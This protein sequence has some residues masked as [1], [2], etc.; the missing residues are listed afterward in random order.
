MIARISIR[1]RLLLLLA[2]P[3]A[4]LVLISSLASN[5]MAKIDE[6]VGRIYD[7]RVVPLRQL[8]A[9]A[10]DYAVSIIDAVNKAN[11]GINPAEETLQAVRKARGDIKAN[12]D[13][14]LKTKLTADEQRLISQADKL[15]RLAEGEI[16]RLVNYL[17]GLHGI[18]GGKMD[19]FDGPLYNFIDPI[20]QKISELV[21]LQLDVAMEERNA[22]NDLYQR[23]SFWFAVGSG[24]VLIVITLLGLVTGASISQPLIRMKEVLS[25]IAQERDLTKPIPIKSQDELGAVAEAVNRMLESFRHAMGEVANSATHLASAS[26][27]LASVSEETNQALRT[28][29]AQTAQVATAVNE[30]A[31]TVHEVAGSATTTAQAAQQA[32]HQAVQGGKVLSETLDS[33]RALASEVSRTAEVIRKLDEQSQAISLVLDV[34]GNIAQQT[35]LLALNAAIEAARAGEQ[36][37]G[38]AVVAAE[39]RTLASR[40]QASTEEIRGMIENLQKGTGEVVQAMAAGH[41]QAET[42]VALTNRAGAVLERITQA[43]VTIRDM[44]AQIASAAQQ[45]GVVAE[46]INRNVSDINTVTS[47]SVLASHQ[48]AEAS[49]ELA[50]LATTLE[51]QVSLFRI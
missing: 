45:Q 31:A 23:A 24:A 37:R 44:S 47:E 22:A 48:V 32:D 39:V 36:G 43:V 14:Y 13:A 25:T 30:M 17:A 42:T 1:G 15:L 12:W 10:D 29:G 9:I 11:A 21:D 41:A 40:T 6:G 28:Q 4:T 46:D 49:G 3:L 34:I 20:S 33:I 27:E 19:S 51:H 16:D 2:L 7:D 35:N 18:I 8:K 26:E 50:R 38:F 5:N